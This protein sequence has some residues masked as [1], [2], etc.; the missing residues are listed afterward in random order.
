MTCLLPFN[1]VYF[2][3]NPVLHLPGWVCEGICSLCCFQHALYN[4]KQL[5]FSLPHFPTFCKWISHFLL[6]YR[7]FPDVHLCFKFLFYR[8]NWSLFAF[9]IHDNMFGDKFYLSY[10]N[11]FWLK[12]GRGEESLKTGMHVICFQRN[13]AGHIQWGHWRPNKATSPALGGGGPSG[14]AFHTFCHPLIKALSPAWSLRS[15]PFLG[16][17][18]VAVSLQRV[19][20]ISCD[21]KQEVKDFYKHVCV[22]QPDGPLGKLTCQ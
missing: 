1:P 17:P 12:K 5:D 22:L 19:L 7:T 6:S 15:S 21:M 14:S 13:A 4:F 16:A 20:A 11:N 18:W 10:D 8:G 3:L 9:L 2:L